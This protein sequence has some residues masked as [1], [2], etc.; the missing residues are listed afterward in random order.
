[1]GSMAVGSQDSFEYSGNIDLPNR[2]RVKNK[3]GSISTV[4]SI[5]FND[6]EKEVVIP[7]VS[8]DGRIMSDKEAINNYFKTGKH[9]GKYDTVKDAEKAAQNIHNQQAKYI[10]EKKRG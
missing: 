5:S 3:D 2:P 6:G 4:R 9:L 10:K 8:D 7:T 1:M